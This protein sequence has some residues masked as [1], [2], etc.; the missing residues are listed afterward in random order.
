[1][2]IDHIETINLLFNYDQGFAYAGGSCTGRVTT[3]VLVRT[4]DGRTGVGSAYSHPGLLYLIIQRQL[5]PMLIGKDPRDVET[6]WDLMYNSTRWYGR[7]GVAMTALGGLDTAFWDLRGQAA[8]KPIFELLGGESATCPAYGSA[9]LW[10]SPEELAKEACQLVENGFRRMKMR[11]GRGAETDAAVLKTIRK[12]VGPDIDL[13]IDGSM[14]YEFEEA[15]DLARLLEEYRAFWFE[16][17]F[18]PEEIDLYKELRGFVTVPI[19][20]GENE[21]GLQGFRELI[22]GGAV[23]I[24]QPDASRCGGI[25]ETLRVAWLAQR[26]GLNFAPHSWCDA[27]AIVANA[28]LVASQPNGVTVE[29]DQTGNPFV[30]QLLAEPLTVSE[31]MIKLSDKPGLGIE[32]NAKMVD[33]YRLPDPLLLPN[34]MYSDMAFGDALLKP[35]SS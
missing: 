31:G 24:V 21:F 17:P 22:R 2:K 12:A 7:K 10:N 29:I 32:L 4:D 13:M 19:A 34:G 11:L 30:E 25:T 20:A 6:L 27:V 18:P 3:L 23:D 15:L 14:R 16:E 33:E 8:D 5:A 1:M 35:I 28:H 26:S 9:L